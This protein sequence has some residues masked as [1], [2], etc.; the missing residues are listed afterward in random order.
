MTCLFRRLIL[1]LCAA[2]GWL[3]MP[4]ATLDE[5]APPDETSEYILI[6]GWVPPVYPPD[7][8][9]EKI[10]GPVMVRFIAD[11]QGRVTAA[12]VISA[13]DPRLGEAAVAAV[14]GW[15][16]VPPQED[17]RALACCLDVKLEFDPAQ[18]ARWPKA[19]APPPPDL[20]PYTAPTINAQPRVTP[21]GDYPDIMRTS[22]LSGVVMFHAIVT[23]EGRIQQ[24]EII[25]GSHADFVP[26][27][28]EA[29]RHWEFTPAMQGDLP[30]RSEIDGRVTFTAEDVTPAE[31]LEANGISLPDG[32]APGPAPEVKQAC[33]PVWPH[34]LLLNGEGGTAIVEFT[35]TPN[36][37][38]R[39]VS[40]FQATHPDFGRSV[41]AAVETWRFAAGDG[42]P[43]E[44]V[45]LRKI[46]TFKR[47]PPELKESADPVT[48]LVIALRAGQVGSAKGLDEKLTP[49]YR[50]RPRFPE[51]FRGA[52]APANGRADIEFIVDRTGRARLPR[53]VSATQPEFGWAAATAVAQWVF[54]APTRAGEPVDVKVRIP[55]E[56]APPAE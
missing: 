13:S 36:G 50:V 46:T 54:K 16:I 53:I 7:A 55:F 25:A 47:V 32:G 12:R 29:L 40:V 5:L 22:R 9:K 8:R 2:A 4:A 41:A 42:L 43:L 10:G 35:V 17:G 39:D 48:R 52:E 1:P 26:A 34:G 24:P 33:D 51:S 23:G 20:L 6:S 31:V 18:P 38:V 11:E 27:A 30:L 14:K 56:F 21:E 15:E 3:S 28:L 19:G 45:R 44:R 49:I 37:A